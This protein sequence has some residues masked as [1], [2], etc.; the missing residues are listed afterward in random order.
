MIA[1][2]SRK[3][4]TTCAKDKVYAWMIAIMC[5]SSLISSCGDDTP[6]SSAPTLTYLG[7]DQDTMLQGTVG[8]ALIVS[9]SFEDADGDLSTVDDLFNVSITDQRDGSVDPVTLPI[10]PTNDGGQKGR[11]ELEIDR[12]CCL[13][14]G[15]DPCITEDVSKVGY[16]EVIY[17][18][19]IR[20]V[21]GNLSNVVSTDPI[22]I[23]CR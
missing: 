20:D 17:D 14:V 4:I 9:L 5:G 1:P 12:T 18:I 22:T 15:F 6:P 7:I 3:T 13:I 10:L 11:I 2:K 16:D 21:A 8:L 19:Q 23:I